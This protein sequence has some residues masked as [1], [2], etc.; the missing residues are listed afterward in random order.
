MASTMTIRISITAFVLAGET[1][2]AVQAVQKNREFSRCQIIN[3]EGSIKEAIK[4][5]SENESPNLLIVE[6]NLSGDAL[7]EEL[8]SL[9][10]VFDPNSRLMLIGQENR[11]QL[12]RQLKNMGIHEYLC[13][14]I[15]SEQLQSSIS[16]LYADPEAIE[17][18]R[19]IACVGASGGAGS[20][21]VAANLAYTL[22]QTYSSEV[23][24]VDLDLC[25]GTAALALN[26]QQR[27]SIA[28]ALAQPDRLD[29]VMIER[30]ML[31]YN[32][33]LS[34]VAAPTVLGGD[35]EISL[36]AFETLLDLVRR[37]ASFIVLDV[38]HQWSPWVNEVLLDANEVL[39]IAYPDLVNLRDAQAI[40][41]RLME[42]RNVDAPTRLI[43]NRVGM[44]KRT[45]LGP[46]DFKGPVT[47]TPT[48]NIPF[49]PNLFGM[50]L[51]NGKSVVEENKRAKSTK[52]F[53]EL[54]KIVSGR[55][56]SEK[57]R[58]GRMVP[59]FLRSDK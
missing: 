6:T 21:T 13:S 35:H 48:L 49:E 10:N 41:D 43:L 36:N 34:V 37:M 59:N 9:A 57:Q 51:N 26:L 52:L 54:A 15:E 23:I 17:L 2:A 45:E 58:P 46:N 40:F 11:I 33:Y 28:D 22:G 47:M 29:D 19:V 30:F 27:Q 16:Q 7:F 3:H 31:K 18:G 53:D 14:P 50:A 25:F 42:K 4:Y 44:A 12:Y 32:D 8:K 55:I 39:V 38:P 20:S 24:L 1:T 56:Q 5:L